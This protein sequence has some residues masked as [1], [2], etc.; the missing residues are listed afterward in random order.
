MFKCVSNY[1]AIITGLTVMKRMVN[2]GVYKVLSI[3][4]KI[5]TQINGSNY[6][7]INSEKQCRTGDSDETK[8]IRES[9]M[10]LTRWARQISEVD[11]ASIRTVI[12]SGVGAYKDS[13]AVSVKGSVCAHLLFV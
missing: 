10:D 2:E 3:Y 5:T 1:K 11:L 13:S 9:S 7:N 8:V 4:Y 12:N 6:I